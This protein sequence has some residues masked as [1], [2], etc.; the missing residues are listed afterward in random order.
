MFMALDAY[1][2][3]YSAQSLTSTVQAQKYAQVLS[4]GFSD[5]DSALT[6]IEKA[7][8]SGA[9]DGT[10]ESLSDNLYDAYGL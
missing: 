10:I 4:K 2:G 6:A 3:M 8:A 5:I 9:D 1:A 7:F